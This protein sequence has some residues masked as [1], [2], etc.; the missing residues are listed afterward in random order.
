MRSYDAMAES[1]W[2]SLAMTLLL[3]G[4]ETTAN[5]LTFAFLLLTENP[6][7]AAELRRESARVLGDLR[8]LAAIGACN[9][10]YIV[11]V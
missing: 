3:A 7:A 2:P 1:N 5:A 10:E 8:S 6:A 11:I 9:N 4:H